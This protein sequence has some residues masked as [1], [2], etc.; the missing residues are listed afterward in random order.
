VV[1]AT[2]AG[3]RVRTDVAAGVA[4]ITLANVDA[5]NAIDVP[6][7]HEIRVHVEDAARRDDVGAIL[8]RAD[9]PAWCVGGALDVFRESGDGVH[10]YITEIGRAFIPLVTTLHECQKI[11]IAA[12]HGAVGGGGVGLML[13]HD[14][15]I[16][17]EGTIMAL[18][19]SRI[20]TNPDG[21]SSHFLVR[22]LGYRRA[23]ELYLLNERIDA[24]QALEL[25]M[26]NRLTARDE[27]DAA[28]GAYAKTVAAGPWHAQGATK[29]LLRQAQ[30]GL[31]ARQLDDEFR[32][33][34]DHTRE[35][36]FAEGVRSFLEKR[37]PRFGA[38]ADAEV[39]AN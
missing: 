6:F 4:T 38:S 36:D 13:A 24:A 20:G 9:G 15:V 30:D 23:L 12:V 8:I 31:L 25:G 3:G 35:P 33:F 10:D 34:A 26:I 16:A 19:Y 29:R 39:E 32:M 1:T 18:G 2:V 7:A 5:R 27:L 14:V 11:T 37:A 22:D 21:G 17:A 28:A